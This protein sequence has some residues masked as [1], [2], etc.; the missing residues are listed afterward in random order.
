MH[1][2]FTW[3]H[4]AGTSSKGWHKCRAPDRLYT[5]AQCNVFSMIWCISRS[6]PSE[7][8]TT[9]CLPPNSAE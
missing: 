9:M 1:P 8:M 3:V 6:S 7:G 2:V 4:C 5:L